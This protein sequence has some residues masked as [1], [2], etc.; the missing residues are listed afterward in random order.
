MKG[1]NPEVYT[2]LKESSLVIIKP[3]GVER[4]LIGRIVDMYER[5]GMK[6]SN[7]KMLNIDRELAENHY[8]EHKGKHFYNELIDYIISGPSVALIL[9]GEAAVKTIREI[10]EE[11]RAAYG[12]STTR[13]TVHGSD[14][15]E[16]AEREI[17]L[18]FGVSA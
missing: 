5:K 1:I 11:I 12:V 8:S 2:V 15:A 6:V 14:S 7:I 18:F 17:S 4:N 13:N 16:S 10:N 9:T 3:D